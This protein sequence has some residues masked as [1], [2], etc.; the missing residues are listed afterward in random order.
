MPAVGRL[1]G[2]AEEGGSILT[3]AGVGQ[4]SQPVQASY[5]SATVTV[6]DTGTTDLSTIYADSSLTPKSNPFT[7]DGTIGFWFFYAEAGRYDIKFSGTG[8]STPFTLEDV[9]LCCTD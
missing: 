9:F 6:Y 2:W 7:L 5:P 1:F 3:V 4:I 8:I